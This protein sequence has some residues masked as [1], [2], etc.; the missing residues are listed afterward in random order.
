MGVC[1]KVWEYEILSLFEFTSPGNPATIWVQ[2]P[3]DDK[4]ASNGTEKGGNLGEWDTMR[5][6]EEEG[7]EEEDTKRRRRRHKKKETSAIENLILMGGG[8]CSIQLREKP[9]VD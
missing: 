2:T 9:V 8:E 5:E 7:E 3:S 4:A 1:L 6:K